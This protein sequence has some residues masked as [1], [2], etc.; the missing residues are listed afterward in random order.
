MISKLALA[1]KA[2][3]IGC[4]LLFQN[5]DSGYNQEADVPENNFSAMEGADQHKVRCCFYPINAERCVQHLLSERLRLS[6]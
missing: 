3:K 5:S 6:A 2:F 1:W 4:L